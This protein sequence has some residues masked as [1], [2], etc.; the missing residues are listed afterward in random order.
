[1]TRWD[2]GM[3]KQ[4]GGVDVL[5]YDQNYRQPAK[6]PTDRLISGLASEMASK[7]WKKNMWSD[8]A[9]LPLFS[10]SVFIFCRAHMT[11]SRQ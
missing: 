7:T 10:R 1:M 8:G 9:A 4:N 2:A 11:S 6:S 3:Q 5:R